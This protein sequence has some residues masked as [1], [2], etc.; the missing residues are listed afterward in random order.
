ERERRKGDLQL[1]EITSTRRDPDGVEISLSPLSLFA[2][3]LSHP[4]P[5]AMTADSSLRPPPY[6][7]WVMRVLERHPESETA[8]MVGTT[9]KF[10]F[11]YYSERDSTHVV[12]FENVLR[13]V[14]QARPEKR[15]GG[16]SRLIERMRGAPEPR[17]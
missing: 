10:L 16:L 4:S 9:G 13:V 6:R 1:R 15:S 11:L 12:P 17:P 2:S 8:T 14:T 7:P 3:A 5:Y